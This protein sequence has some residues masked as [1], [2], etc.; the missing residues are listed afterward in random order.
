[1]HD[2]GNFNL[3]ATQ[4]LELV[5]VKELATV[6]GVNIK[7]VMRAAESLRNKNHP[8]F[9]IIDNKKRVGKRFAIAYDETQVTAIKKEIAYHHNLALRLIDNVSTELE[10]IENYKHSSE[11][12]VSLLQ[13]KNKALQNRLEIAESKAQW[14]D[15]FS[16]SSDLVYISDVGKRLEGFGLGG[17]KLFKRLLADKIIYIKEVNG[18]KSYYNYAQYKDFFVLK[19]KMYK[20]VNGKTRIRPTLFVTQ[21]GVQ[22]LEDKYSKGGVYAIAGADEL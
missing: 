10:V 12:L 13:E 4:D 11:A 2:M 17:L 15:D 8:A 16:E 20:D 6:L 1:M 5:T 7:T 9:S 19:E 14:Y 18:V 22:F 3:P 21:K